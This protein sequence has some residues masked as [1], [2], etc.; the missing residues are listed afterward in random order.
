MEY[1]GK[2]GWI[3][4]K[5]RSFSLRSWLTLGMCVVLLPFAFTAFYGYK[6]YHQEISSTFEDVIHAQHRVLV[7]LER[8]QDIFWDISEE[9]NDYSQDGEV[10]HQLGFA[11]SKKAVQKQLL[12]MEAAIAENSRYEHILRGVQSHWQ[13]VLDVAPSVVKGSP[14]TADPKLLIFESEISEAAQQLGLLAEVLRIE[15]EKAHRTTLIAIRRLET[16]AIWAAIFA[17]GFAVVAIYTIDRV[18][19]NSTDKLVEG[20]MRVASGEREQVIDIQVPPE[21]ASVAK[22][23]NIMTKQIVLQEAQLQSAARFDGLTGLKNRREFDLRLAEQ[24]EKEKA[25]SYPFALLMIDVDH[26]KIFNDT[27]GHLAGDDALRHIANVLAKAARESDEVFRYGGEEFV[28]LLSDI[29]RDQIFQTAERIRS[30]VEKSQILLPTGECE[31]ITVSIGATGFANG[32]SF[33]DI[34]GQADRA[35]YQAKASG[36]NK[37]VMAKS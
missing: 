15:S 12:E 4:G 10:A 31:T 35:L 32:L 14:S 28:I 5:A 30:E 1:G 36:R 18:L 22:A 11:T 17:V 33:N 21:L 27:H 19:I 34:V 26:F 8:M 24:F 3:F 6:I 13:R 23:F 20:A 37:V 29:K 16:I 25:Q 2:L 7:P 9:I